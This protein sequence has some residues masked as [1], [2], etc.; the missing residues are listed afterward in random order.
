M[1]IGTGILTTNRKG[2]FNIGRTPKLQL[3]LNKCWYINALDDAYKNGLDSFF[4][5]KRTM[6]D[7]SSFLSGEEY[8]FLQ[9]V[10]YNHLNL[11]FRIQRCICKWKSLRRKQFSNIINKK[12]LFLQSFNDTDS[13]ILV[14][15]KNGYFQFHAHELIKIYLISIYEAYKMGA[16]QC[17]TKNPY[18][19]TNFSIPQNY[20]IYDELRNKNAA[21]KIPPILI[22]FF[23]NL[24]NFDYFVAKNCYSLEEKFR[25][26]FYYL[27]SNYTFMDFVY[28]FLTKYSWREISRDKLFEL[29]VTKTRNLLIHLMVH[30]HMQSFINPSYRM[31]TNDRITADVTNFVFENKLMKS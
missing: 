29:D 18:T 2:L 20:Y 24:G 7:N 5:L 31:R 19:M 4:K 25:Y 21:V 11:R 14:F 15:D 17:V 9:T 13:T 1:N 16:R 8:E 12:D 27:A 23:H 22:E 10:I 3:S 26:D 28:S 30:D 6:I